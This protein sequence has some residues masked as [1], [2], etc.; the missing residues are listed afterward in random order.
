M[1][2][3]NKNIIKREVPTNKIKIKIGKETIEFNKNVFFDK[4]PAKNIIRILK[5]DAKELKNLTKYYNHFNL[6]KTNHKIGELYLLP[7]IEKQGK[8]EDKKQ[9][10]PTLSFENILL[11]KCIDVKNNISYDELTD[12]DFIFSLPTIKNSKQ[13][14]LAILKRYKKS[15]PNL[16]N[17]EIIDAGV[18]LTKL[19]II[20]TFSYNSKFNWGSMR[21]GFGKA[22]VEI[23]KRN[24]NVLALTADLKESLNLT[25]FEEKYPSRFYEFSISEQNMMSAA[26]GMT[27]A[28][29]IPFCASYA[30]FN[31]GRNYDQLRVSVCYSN[32]NVKIVGSHAGLTTGPDGATHQMLE[33]IAI[34]RCL[35]NLTVIIPCDEEEARK[36]TIAAAKHK[37]PVYI[38]LSREKTP[39]I[40]KKE[41]EF[42]IGKADIL[43][44]GKDICI[45]SCGVALQFALK[46]EQELSK[47]NISSTVINLHTIKPLDKKTILDSVKKT[48][49]IITLEEHQIYGGMG[50]AVAELI[51]QNCPKPLKILGISDKFGESGDGYKLLDKY[52]IS[53]KE[54]IKSA[55]E[56]LNNL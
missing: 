2:K 55:K 40:T 12:E 27:I 8:Y 39:N 18:S 54:I 6:Q 28:G 34:T 21:K 25:E 7:I 52:K 26:A 15:L 33:D 41:S 47:Y 31:P 32:A 38:R 22:M 37:G 36:A 11:C 23:G 50:S 49:G 29:K 9:I 19:E 5:D 20:D 14:K 45:I 44:K 10:L 46:A 48:K 24:N 42:K 16:S 30:A 35:P 1:Q 13:L 53:E 51:S 17:K 4:L 3:K 43:K 56:I